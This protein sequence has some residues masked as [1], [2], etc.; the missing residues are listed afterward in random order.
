MIKVLSNAIS[1]N[2]LHMLMTALIK[3][4]NNV[5]TEAKLVGPYIN[6]DKICT[7]RG[8]IH[9]NNFSFDKF[10]NFTYLGSLLSENNLMQHEISERI[11]K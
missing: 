8:Q 2:L 9:I 6:E 4:F 3:L 7:L 10:C 5:R 1:C 11:C